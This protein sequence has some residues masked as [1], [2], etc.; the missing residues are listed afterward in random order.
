MAAS[1]IFFPEN[2]RNPGN[3]RPQNEQ[4]SSINVKKTKTAAVGDGRRHGVLR[5]ANFIDEK[6]LDRTLGSE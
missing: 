2:A 6:G 5:Y 4:P 3:F 1:A